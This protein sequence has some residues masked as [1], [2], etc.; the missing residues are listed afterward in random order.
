[1]N[2]I[3]LTGPYLFFFFYYLKGGIVLYFLVKNCF[4][5][6]INF[7]RLPHILFGI[8]IGGH[9]S[10]GHHFDAFNE[11]LFCSNYCLALEEFALVTTLML[12][13]SSALV[14]AP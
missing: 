5:K 6:N 8:G 3:L 9:D 14:I 13:R 7:S 10:I 1:M 12:S 11:F 4:Y 2:I